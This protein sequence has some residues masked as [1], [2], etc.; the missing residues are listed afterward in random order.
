MLGF[1]AM[2]HGAMRQH[3]DVQY[4]D[5]NCERLHGWP[6]CSC[7]IA[8]QLR[9]SL[10]PGDFWSMMSLFAWGGTWWLPAM[11]YGHW[12]TCPN[13]AL[14]EVRQYLASRIHAWF[15]PKSTHSS[16]FYKEC[17]SPYN[18]HFHI[19]NACGRNLV[20]V[21]LIVH[22]MDVGTMVAKVALILWCF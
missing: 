22:V 17:T 12:G 10:L 14:G 8:I 15:K 9:L 21:A 18:R 16:S 13:A 7:C 1:G 2:I 11:P 20:I 19:Y 4:E 5:R 3:T 6:G